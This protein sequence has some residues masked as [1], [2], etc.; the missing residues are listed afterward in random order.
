VKRWG[1]ERCGFTVV[2]KLEN[3]G[4]N[5]QVGDGAEPRCCCFSF[6]PSVFG[7]ILGGDLNCGTPPPRLLI[8]LA[9]FTRDTFWHNHVQ[10]MRLNCL[11]IIF[12][13]SNSVIIVIT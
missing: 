1:E 3:S 7:E 11:P 10:V 12:Y 2:K 13:V 9:C 8:L 4:L 5:R 6:P